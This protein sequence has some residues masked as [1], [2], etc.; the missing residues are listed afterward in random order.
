MNIYFLLKLDINVILLEIFKEKKCEFCSI[1]D[2]Y[3]IKKKKK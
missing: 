1:D 3:K 2:F